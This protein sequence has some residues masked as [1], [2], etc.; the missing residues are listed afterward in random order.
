MYIKNIYEILN[1]Q[2]I[3]IY[4]IIIII[5]IIVFLANTHT[6]IIFAPHLPQPPA[7]THVHSVAIVCIS[8]FLCFN[9]PFSF[10]APSF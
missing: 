6:H 4:K 3:R 10:L 1:V 7:A 8:V 9:L 2:F 5:I